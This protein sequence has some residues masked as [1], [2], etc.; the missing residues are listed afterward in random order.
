MEYRVFGKNGFQVPVI[1]FG[2]GHIGGN[3]LTDAEVDTL[4]NSALDAG[5]T[6]IDTARGY[7]LSE[8]RIGKFLCHRRHDFI[9]STKVG[10]S[11][12]GY[13]DW[14]YD[15]VTAGIDNALRL[16][17]TDYLDIVHLHSCPLWMLQKGEVTA[18]LCAARDAGK[19][20]SAAYSGENE[21]L[22]F[23][24]NTGAFDSVQTSM[25][26]FDQRST[27]W[28][29]NEAV[30]RRM[31]IIAKR[32]AGNC[33]WKYQERPE[34]QYADAYWLRMKAMELD[35]GSD[36]L[37]V[38]LRYTAFHT[39]AH[40]LIVGTGQLAHLLENVKLTEAGPLPEDI[41]QL[42]TSRFG[43]HE[44]EWGGEV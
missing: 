44:A 8:E 34:G 38:A 40:S 3:N 13:E 24:I 26:V 14:T 39:G 1:G 31:G 30:R 35:F 17:Q 27:R 18:A 10:Y 32:P 11:I 22:G 42:I 20:R 25:N 9:L 7:N 12:P 41:L 23:A 36:W 5:V 21:E 37:S 6:L 16:L 29:A 28:Y 33:A 4:L 43:P 19:L 15:C 2:A